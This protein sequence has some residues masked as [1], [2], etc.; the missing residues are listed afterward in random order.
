MYHLFVTQGPRDLFQTIMKHMRINYKHKKE[1]LKQ[2]LLRKSLL[3]SFG[4]I[5]T[6]PIF[7]IL[8]F[9]GE[10]NQTT[11]YLHYLLTNC[12]ILLFSYGLDKD[13]RSGE[14]PLECRPC[15][16]NYCPNTLRRMMA[17]PVAA[18][19]WSFDRTRGIPKRLSF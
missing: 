6:K 9:G 10:R 17:E 2:N 5:L 7:S 1:K 15:F 13:G 16:G 12:M 19:F 11:T 18:A 8:K 3:P 4:R 14:P